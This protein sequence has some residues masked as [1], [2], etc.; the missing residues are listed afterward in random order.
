M[1]TEEAKNVASIRISKHA[2]LRYNERVAKSSVRG[3][4]TLILDAINSGY[5]LED[6]RDGL[7]LR[8]GNVR[9]V[10][11]RKQS[12][13]TLWLVTVTLTKETRMS[14]TESMQAGIAKTGGGFA[15]PEIFRNAQPSVIQART[16][17]PTVTF[18]H[19]KR[20]DE[21]TKLVGKFGSVDEGDMYFIYKDVVE[22]LDVAKL[23]WVT[24]TQYWVHKTA[25]GEVKA[26]SFSEKPDPF[27][28]GVE[29]VV[30][31]YLDD[32]MYPA[33]M[34]F[35][36]TKCGGAR[37][38]NDG[39]AAAMDV[40]WFEQSAA[41]R[42]TAMI[43]QP[44]MRFYGE[45]RLADARPSKSSG[46]PYKPMTVTIKPVTLPE[47]R[48]ASEFSNNPEGGTLFQMVA[49]RYESVMKELREKEVA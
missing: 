2:L 4:E 10:L 46:L 45:T 42:E 33:N 35:R 19:P 18:A 31:V 25:V 41:H 3:I 37:A 16:W 38:L 36:T 30:I 15:M 48:L 28:E 22:K 43:Q 27:K 39:L 44:F 49:A 1:R 11:K 23:G 12:N 40:S 34:K 9:Y 8:M 47:I 7:I 20:K 26:V 29:A 14:K 21:W 13:R 17:A 6:G 5:P 24:G 32:A